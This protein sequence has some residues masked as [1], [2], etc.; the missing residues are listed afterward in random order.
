M[1]RWGG[2]GNAEFRRDVAAA[3]RERK[4]VRL[5]VARTDDTAHVQSGG[6]ASKIKKDFHVRD[7][8]IGEVV[9]FDGENYVFRFISAPSR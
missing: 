2:L 9:E 4:P 3:Y 7:D 1:S 5:V 6:D 8:L